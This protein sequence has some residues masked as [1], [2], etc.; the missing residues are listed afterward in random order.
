MVVDRASTDSGK[1]RSTYANYRDAS[2]CFITSPIVAV[3][4]DFVVER[5]C[6]ISFRSICFTAAR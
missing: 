4:D 2:F 3:E 1:L 5:Y 6:S